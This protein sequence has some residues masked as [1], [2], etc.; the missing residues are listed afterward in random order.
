MRWN[1]GSLELL[2]QTKL[3]TTIEYIQCDNY[4]IVAEAI[5]KLEVRGAPAIGAAAAFGYVLGAKQFQS[6]ELK[7]FISRL[8]HVSE[9]LRA[10]RPTAVNLFWALDRMDNLLRQHLQKKSSMKE[11]IFSL[12]EE[13]IRIAD[14]DK[15]VNCALSKYGAD[16][17]KSPMNFLTHCNAGALATVDMGTALGVIR[18]TYADGH[19]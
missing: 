16:L 13:A 9:E 2:D 18:Q 4:Q 6:L 3:P 8:E 7:N 5:K 17:F 15:K 11:I 10:T 1:H 12:E 14:E 19:V